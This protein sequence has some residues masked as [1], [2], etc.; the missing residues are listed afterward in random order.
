MYDDVVTAQV[1]THARQGA[2]QKDPTPGR[3]PLPRNRIYENVQI[4]G[5]FIPDVIHLKTPGT[6]GGVHKDNVLNEA[7]CSDSMPGFGQVYQNADM[8]GDETDAD[9]A[10]YDEVSMDQIRITIPHPV[11]A[12]RQSLTLQRSTGDVSED[13]YCEIGDTMESGGKPQPPVRTAS[14]RDPPNHKPPK[15][16]IKPK[17]KVGSLKRWLDKATGRHKE[18]EVSPDSLIDVQMVENEVYESEEVCKS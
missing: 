9:K 16:P 10:S 8:T 14:R 13:V 12:K 5:G 7:R 3:L 17:P 18:P 11:P 6:A 1:E 4:N 15:P 2:A